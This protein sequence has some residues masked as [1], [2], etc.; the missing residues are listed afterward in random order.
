MEY[1]KQIFSSNRNKNKA[2]YKQQVDLPVD[3]SVLSLS[4]KSQPVKAYHSRPFYNYQYSNDSHIEHATTTFIPQDRGR[5]QTI[6]WLNSGTSESLV[7]LL[8]EQERAAK[9]VRRGP[10]TKGT[11][12]V[13]AI[14]NKPSRKTVE[15]L[16]R[17]RERAEMAVRYSTPGVVIYNF[18]KSCGWN[19]AS[20]S[21]IPSLQLRDHRLSVS[22][23]PSSPINS[24]V[25][26]NLGILVARCP[27]QQASGC[28][29]QFHSWS[30]VSEPGGW[31]DTEQMNIPSVKPDINTHTAPVKGRERDV[32]ISEEEH[33][34]EEGAYDPYNSN[35]VPATPSESQATAIRIIPVYNQHIR[36]VQLG[37]V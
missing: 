17:V 5:E 6:E 22:T 21:R 12:E 33:K 35:D 20:A 37:M 26:P 29:E 31:R 11:R 2:K 8:T 13:H 7:A 3:E 34:G 4:P 19:R 18:S 9:Q 23:V 16:H 27:Q 10:R 32:V 28:E 15:K 36:V 14:L 24:L 30:P 1:I 25:R